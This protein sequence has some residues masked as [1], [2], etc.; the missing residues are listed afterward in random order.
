[1]NDHLRRFL[2]VA[3]LL[4]AASPAAA[5]PPVD[6]GQRLLEQ[7]QQRQLE[8]EEKR[9][10]GEVEIKPE[11]P[12]PP[13]PD[14]GVCFEIDRIVLD[15]AT[16]LEPAARDAILARYAGRCLSRKDINRL[17]GA[18]TEAYVERGYVTT[19]VYIPPQNLSS[20][21]LRLL[22]I[23]GRVER[24]QLN[25]NSAADRRRAAA[26]FPLAGGDILQLRDIE[27]GL[28]QL[29][30]VP[31]A[32]ASVQLEP[33]T[34]PGATVVVA[35]DH[36]QDRF[37]GYV[38]YDNFGQEA[39]G[40]QRIQFGV[41]ADNVLSLNDTWA[42]VYAGALDTNAVA[43]NGSVGLGHWTLGA[44]FSYSEFL[45]RLTPDAELFGRGMVAGMFVDLLLGRTRTTKTSLV[46]QLDRK[47]SRRYVNDV[48]LV[49]QD[50]TVAQLG[51]RS[52]IRLPAGAVFIDG[53]FS[54]GLDVLG[55]T[56][57]HGAQPDEPRAQF[58]KLDA[59]VSWLGRLGRATLRS[60]GRGQYSEDPLYG[61]EQIVLGGAHTVRGYEEAAASGDSGW[62]TRNELTF[63]LRPGALELGG[64]HWSPSLQ[65]YLFADA[66]QVFLRAGGSSR[67]VGG[68]GTGLRVSGTWLSVDLALAYPFVRNDLPRQ[69]VFAR[70]VF[71][72]W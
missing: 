40:E 47:A 62:F 22:V 10:P 34:E 55:A 51:A 14:E 71:Q 30:R 18:L 63:D 67:S 1:M 32:R 12:P 65:P 19:R 16:L 25:E 64:T 49:P 5:Q 9:E 69:E 29:N 24:L 33:G 72:P 56:S 7:L 4:A 31:S 21:V 42:L 48:E 20:G 37:R 28:D 2:A 43:A 36:P 59:G 66:G 23:E 41:E 8:R 46:L 11:A 17:L 68:I 38:G 70:V 27:Q 35:R 52:Q 6:P 44:L 61:S 57:D 26:A 45:L 39:T 3:A 54:V 58:I 60:T 15:G 13:A 53:T 50:L